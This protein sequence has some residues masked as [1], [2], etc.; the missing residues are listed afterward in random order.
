MQRLQLYVKSS[1]RYN[2]TRHQVV[3]LVITFKPATSDANAMDLTRSK[4][5]VEEKKR[6]QT[7]ELCFYCGQA[8]HQTFSCPLKPANTYVWA[9]QNTQDTS[10]AQPTPDTPQD[11]GKE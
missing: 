5:T 6:C 2:S 4:L 11:L 8:G 9:I 7:K 1:Q 3:I 10:A